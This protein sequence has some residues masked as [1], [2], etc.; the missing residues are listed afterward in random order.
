MGRKQYRNTVDR[1]AGA[2]SPK[3]KFWDEARHVL[4]LISKHSP[5]GP[6]TGTVLSTSGYRY[7]NR[8]TIL[9]FAA[10]YDAGFRSSPSLL[11]AYGC[12]TKF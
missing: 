8:G 6:D 9:H 4:L 10:F 3:V 11:G 12:S 7:R 5:P 1:P 2:I